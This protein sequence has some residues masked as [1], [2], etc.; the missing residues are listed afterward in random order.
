MKNN[1]DH[2]VFYCGTFRGQF[3][4]QSNKKKCFPDCF[5]IFLKALRYG[6]I[7]ES[8][9]IRVPG[10]RFKP[11]FGNCK[12]YRE[13]KV[14][15]IKHDKYRI[16]FADYRGTFL[17][18]QCY[19]KNNNDEMNY[20]KAGKDLDGL[21]HDDYSNYVEHDFKNKPKSRFLNKLS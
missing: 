20:I 13:L 19:M 7:T 6:E 14:V 18:L 21:I 9:I 15:G 12:K 4:K 10:N 1:L 16:I 5:D 3:K 17:F 2:R 8:H 11:E